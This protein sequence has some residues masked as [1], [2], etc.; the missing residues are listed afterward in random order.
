LTEQLWQRINK[1]D[2]MKLK[3]FCTNK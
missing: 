2:Y 1:F 3:S